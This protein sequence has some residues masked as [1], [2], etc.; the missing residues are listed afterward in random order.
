MLSRFVKCFGYPEQTP[1]IRSARGVYPTCTTYPALT[2][3]AIFTM[4]L[5]RRSLHAFLPPGLRRRVRASGWLA[6][7]G[8]L[9]A[10]GPASANHALRVGLYE[11]PPKIF[12]SPSGQPTGSFVG[13]LQEIA[14]A[15]GWELEFKPCEWQACLNRLEAGELD[16]MPDVAISSEREKRFDFHKTP[17]MHSWSQLYRR[18][19]I[20]V[21]SPLDLE[22]KRVAVLASGVQLDSLSNMLGGF[23]VHFDVVRADTVSEAFKLTASGQADVAAASYHFGEYR[24]REFGLIATPVL[25]QPSKLFFAAPKGLR[26]A[27]L[28]AID[29][30]LDQWMQDDQ[31]PYFAVLK[32]WGVN[33]QANPVSTLLVQALVGVTLTG[34]LLAAGVLWLRQRVR[35]ALADLQASNQ[36]LQA[37]LRAVPDLMFE[38]DAQGRYVA[39]HANQEKLL[40]APPASLR[41]RSVTEVMP[42]EAAQRVLSVI[43]KALETGHC[44]GELIRLD[45]DGTSHWFELSASRKEMPD[46]GQPHAV[47]LSR[48]ITERMTS[49]ARI[50]HLADF[51]QLTGLPNR[52]QLRQLMQQALATA[53]RH[54]HPLAVLFMDLD[55]FKNINDSLGHASGDQ[56][57]VQV[58]ERLKTGRR[59]TDI[60]CRMGGDEFILVLPETNA[61]GASQA[62]LRIRDQM[63][64]AFT[65]GRHEVG[66]GISLG[67]AVY[68]DDGADIDTLLRNADAAMYQAKAEGRNDFRFFTRAMQER[69][70]RTLALSSALAQSLERQ[71]MQVHYQPLV[72]LPTGRVVGAEAL[73][74]WSHPD[75]G[76]VSPGE[77][78][79]VAESAGQILRLGEW[80][81]RE[82]A[83]QARRW[84]DQGQA[85]PVAVN[86]SA[87]QFRHPQFVQ[88]IARVLSESQLP[89][90]LLELEVTESLTMGDPKTAIDTMQALRSLGVRLAIDD[91]GTGYSSLGYLRR[92]GFHKVKIDQSFVHDIGQDAD[93]EAI[94]TAIIQLGHS[95]GMTTLAEG[96]ETEAQRA[97]LAAKGCDMIQGWLISKALPRPAFDAFVAQHAPQASVPVHPLTS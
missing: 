80:V 61:Q 12:T 60:A 47:V 36:Q 86:I 70:D 34:L 41:G 22:G 89:P 79:P 71:Q 43:Q 30:R 48:D 11:N 37:T 65:L 91:F 6:A 68:P 38:M 31:S 87:I 94:I 42:H 25:F 3:S 56:L 45:V 83:Q 53:Q 50:Q 13:L 49:Q 64:A 4:P 76:Q 74:R 27:E 59:D 18:P 19:G 10:V 40:A 57:L 14:K 95:L 46:G 26:Q 97:F 23:N 73:L 69:S 33:A 1:S 72:H 28:Q 21:D 8:W 62:A 77:F 88:R 15:E 84:L 39:V 2:S 52:T 44:S 9:L 55:H 5:P 58:A 75:L 29:V 17:A 90:H 20:R 54:Q 32:R 93:D 24:A 51:D 66:I 63:H 7:V 82:S 81:L 35:N 67:I 85:L 16:L 92:L 78:I 96:V